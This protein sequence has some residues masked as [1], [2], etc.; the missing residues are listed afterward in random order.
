MPLPSTRLQLLP[1][2]TS[3]VCLFCCPAGSVLQTVFEDPN[4]LEP[5]HIQY[6]IE[7]GLISDD[8]IY[9]FSDSR[10]KLWIATDHGVCSFNGERFEAM[11]NEGVSNTTFLLIDEDTLGNLWAVTVMNDIFQLTNGHFVRTPASYHLRGLTRSL[12]ADDFQVIDDKSFITRGVRGTYFVSDTGILSISTLLDDTGFSSI[13]PIDT[14]IVMV[15]QREEKGSVDVFFRNAWIRIPHVFTPGMKFFVNNRM[16]F[17]HTDAAF[18]LTFDDGIYLFSNDTLQYIQ[19]PSYATNSICFLDDENVLVGTDYRGVVWIRNGKIIDRFLTD[20]Q[21]LTIARDFEGGVWV[22]TE[23]EGLFYIPQLELHWRVQNQYVIWAGLVDDSLVY[24]NRER[25]VFLGASHVGNITLPFKK[26]N[27]LVLDILYEPGVIHFGMNAQDDKVGAWGSVYLSPFRVKRRAKTGF[28]FST[29]T[30]GSDTILGSFSG[31]KRVQGSD[32]PFVFE[33]LDK[34]FRVES[35]IYDAHEKNAFW[36]AT[37]NGIYRMQYNPDS[38]LIFR[39]LEEHVTDRSFKRLINYKNWVIAASNRC[40]LYIK[41]PGSDTFEAKSEWG[42]FSVNCYVVTDQGCYLGTNSALLRLSVSP[43]SEQLELVDISNSIGLAPSSIQDMEIQNEEL[44]LATSKGLLSIPLSMTEQVHEAG[45]NLFLQHVQVNEDVHASN[46]SL[47][48]FTGDRLSFTI[49]TVGYHSLAD[50]RFAYRLLPID[51]TWKYTRNVELSFFGLDAGRYTLE[52]RSLLGSV[53]SYPFQVSDRW[54]QRTWVLVTAAVLLTL[55]LLSPAYYVRKMKVQKL[56]FERNQGKL[57]LQSLSAQLDPHFISNALTSIQSFILKREAQQS[58]DYLSTFAGYIRNVL[59]HARASRVSLEEVLESTRT[60]LDLERLRLDHAFTYTI[61]VAPTI[62]S[63][64]VM[65][66]PML[67]QPY[68]ENAIVH[69][70]TGLSYPGEIV[71]TVTQ[72][73]KKRYAI[74]IEDNGPG[75]NETQKSKH[76][77]FGLSTRINHERIRLLNQVYRSS[78]RVTTERGSEGKGVVCTLY[79]ET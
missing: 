37:R 30:F 20:Q 17:G 35:M 28:A 63:S 51:T 58:S 50:R 78:F 33:S 67:V 69:G 6:T 21:V 68:I 47:E 43:K 7:D 59:H 18:A 26:I 2:W 74:R 25:E 1:F 16:F 66:P 4:P 39:I 13:S 61:N 9:V 36:A 24:I 14:G 46:S 15:V 34:V 11:S 23:G 29:L 12:R 5:Y 38:S 62:D 42:E 71:V 79:M 76:S 65:I 3:F 41:A 52:T 22:G 27:K 45:P 57:Q 73:S 75:I 77:G 48:L 53:S 64:R 19:L 10:G 8:A 31:L 60:Y 56:R 40:P 55:L 49:E 44:I 70:M 54:Y 32:D 72:S